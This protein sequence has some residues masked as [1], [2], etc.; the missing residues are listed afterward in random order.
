MYGNKDDEDDHGTLD[1]DDE[2]V[3]MKNLLK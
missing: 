1:R 2:D 3:S